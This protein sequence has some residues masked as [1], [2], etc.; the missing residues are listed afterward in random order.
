MLTIPAA[1]APVWVLF[2]YMGVFKPTISS[3]V[4]AA[5]GT[6]VALSAAGRPFRYAIIQAKPGN[7]GNIFLGDVTVA[8]GLGI[9]LTPTSA[10]II[11]RNDGNDSR[12]DLADW[13]I[14]AATNG[15]GA[16][17]LIF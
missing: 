8:S 17:I 10:P 6:R 7:T 5:A 3:K 9:T 13:Y 2:L 14:D 12:F 16:N 15:D 11:I 1:I 4:V